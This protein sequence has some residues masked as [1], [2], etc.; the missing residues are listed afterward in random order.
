MDTLELIDSTPGVLYLDFVSQPV[1]NW[2]YLNTS[3]FVFP[4]IYEGFGFPPLEAAT[5]GVVSAVSNVSSIPEVCGDAAVYFDPLDVDD[6]A[7]K[8][9][10]A[11]YDEPTRTLLKGRL[12]PQLDSFSWSRNAA[13][14]IEVY[15]SVIDK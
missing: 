15:K 12:K 10:L 9:F 6:M 8:M 13:E 14:T 2:L 11:L 3:L 1:L 5:C 4:S 7:A